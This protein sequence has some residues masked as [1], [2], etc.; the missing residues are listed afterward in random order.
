MI[1]SSNYLRYDSKYH[2]IMTEDDNDDNSK[3]KCDVT[4]HV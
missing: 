1:H 4:K 3:D 2:M